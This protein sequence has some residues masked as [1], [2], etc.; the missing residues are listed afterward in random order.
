[1]ARLVGRR[2]GTPDSYQAPPR[3]GAALD[4]LEARLPGEGTA[5]AREVAKDPLV[6]DLLGLTEEAEELA[7]EGALTLRMSQTL[8]EFGKGFA[9]YGRQYHLDVGEGFYIDLLLVHVP[10]SERWSSQMP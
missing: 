10:S 9:F 7:I 6:P 4:N 5:L 8:A 1:M 2:P 3:T